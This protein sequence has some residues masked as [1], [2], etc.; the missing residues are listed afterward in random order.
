[1]LKSNNCT[2]TNLKPRFHLFL[3]FCGCTFLSVPYA[4]QLSSWKWSEYTDRQNSNRNIIL[5]QTWL[6]M[7]VSVRLFL[8]QLPPGTWPWSDTPVDLQPPCARYHWAENCR[9]T[10]CNACFNLCMLA[11][12]FRESIDGKAPGYSDMKSQIPTFD[13]SLP[14][15]SCK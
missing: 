12:R 6:S 3:I 14:Q 10:S 15:P 9:T 13:S 7:K 8:A 11:T 1:M 5:V 4:C 2:W